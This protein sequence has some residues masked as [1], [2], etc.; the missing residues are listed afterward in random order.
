MG[1]GASP[2]E[3]QHGFVDNADEHNRRG[4]ENLLSP[5]LQDTL[6]WS[7]GEEDAEEEQYTK[8]EDD[9]GPAEQC[10]KLLDELELGELSVLRRMAKK[11]A[12]PTELRQKVRNLE[13][14]PHRQSKLKT[15]RRNMKRTDNRDSSSSGG[16]RMWV[17]VDERGCPTGAHRPD[18]LTKLRGYSRDLDWSMDNFKAHPRALLMAIK[19]KMA[20]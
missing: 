18:W 13:S 8:Y 14:S 10:T 4:D 3:E 19:D 17:Q 12:D 5:G 15:L 2:E 9:D 7:E 1:G 6:L 11:G 16:G 20:A